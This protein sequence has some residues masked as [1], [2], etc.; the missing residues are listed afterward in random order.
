MSTDTIIP[1]EYIPR[2]APAPEIEDLTGSSQLPALPPMSPLAVR[3]A[4]REE[5]FDAAASIARCRQYAETSQ[6]FA[7][8]SLAM[9]VMAGMQLAEIKRLSPYTQGRKRTPKSNPHDAGLTPT[10]PSGKKPHDAGISENPNEMEVFGSADPFAGFS[11]WEDFLKGSLGISADTAGRWIAMADAARPRLKRLD[12]WAA[13]ITDLIDRPISGL[14]DDEVGVLS[15]AVAKLTDGRTQL[16]FLAELGL[17]KKPGNPQLGGATGGRGQSTGVIDE[18]ALRTA[19]AQDW[20]Q[21]YRALIGGGCTF[22]ALDDAAIESQI[23]ILARALR[24]RRE[25]IGTPAA[26]RNTALVDALGKILA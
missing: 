21:A 17:V 7:R 14:S 12:G 24:A 18:D 16:D 19:A 2:P 23:D 4:V 13:L 3:T 1:T 25:W 6:K 9:Q 5:S 26:K 20:D 11:T 10:P 22:T 15:K 8:A